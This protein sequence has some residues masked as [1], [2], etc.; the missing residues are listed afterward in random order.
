MRVLFLAFS[1][2][3]Y[4]IELAEALCE[5]E[6]VLFMVPQRR[7]EQFARVIN[8]NL[9]LYAFHKPR[10]R[11]PA[12][13]LMTWTSVRQINRFNPDVIHLQHLP[14]EEPWLH[15][16]WEHNINV[17]VKDE[18]LHPYL[19][20]WPLRAFLCRISKKPRMNISEEGG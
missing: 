18:P 10:N 12:S 13:L 16:V 20:S 15:G 11:N 9:P 6:D 8:Q 4:S 19:G 7:F 1:H 17:T 2:I 14:G 5:L 3:E